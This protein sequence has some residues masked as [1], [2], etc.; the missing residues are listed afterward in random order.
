[1]NT[2]ENNKTF[3]ISHLISRLNYRLS[4]DLPSHAP[5]RDKEGERERRAGGRERGSEG[6]EG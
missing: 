3:R 6:K 5:E 1:M 2:R 4:P